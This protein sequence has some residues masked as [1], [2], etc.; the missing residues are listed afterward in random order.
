[1]VAIPLREQGHLHQAVIVVGLKVKSLAIV[2]NGTA[3]THPASRTKPSKYQACAEARFSCRWASQMAAASVRRPAS[4]RHWR[5]PFR[6][7][8]KDGAGLLPPA[9][10]S[11]PLRPSA[12][13]KPALPREAGEGGGALGG[14]AGRWW[15]AAGA[16]RGPG[17]RQANAIGILA[18]TNPG[19]LPAVVPRGRQTTLLPASAGGQFFES[20]PLGRPVKIDSKLRQKMKS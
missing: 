3:I 5:A 4:A 11:S 12:L 19:R 6:A 15:Q 16:A 18:E 20:L 13:M 10:A 17:L 2:I 14:L 8:W 7:G 1:M 9:L